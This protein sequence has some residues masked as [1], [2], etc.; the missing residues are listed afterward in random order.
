[1]SHELNIVNA[2]L[3]GLGLAFAVWLFY[4]ALQRSESPLK[5]AFKVLFTI[6]LLV[7]DLYLIHRIDGSI[8][9][10]GVPANAAP[11]FWVVVLVAAL[12]VILSIIWT[13]HVSDFLFS[14]LTDLF[15]GG[16]QPPERRPAYS[17]ALSKLK[18]N[19]PLEAIVAIREQLAQFPNDYEGV[20]LLATIQAED[21]QDLPGAEITLNRF[22]ES[23][24][25][26]DRQIIKA[27]TKLAEWHL[28]QG[29][30]PDTVL[31]IMERIMIQFPDAKISQR[32]AQ[33][34]GRS[35]TEEISRKKPSALEQANLS[36][37]EATRK[38]FLHFK[39][40]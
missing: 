37:Q 8:H 17:V 5:F 10:G 32:L 1:M 29:S 14:P 11:V 30:D 3:S 25:V 16:H 15:D 24:G 28:D 38:S 20:M 31:A 6:L 4:R 26:P 35:T 12:G 22:C 39:T 36:G 18:N 13:P 23:P 9:V 40:R 27:L 21:L 7:G 19:Q 33:R 34:L 2:L